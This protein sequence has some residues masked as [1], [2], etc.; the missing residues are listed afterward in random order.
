MARAALDQWTPVRRSGS[1][2]CAGNPEI[3]TRLS[4]RGT[5][6]PVGRVYHWFGCRLAR[7]LGVDEQEFGPV[8]PTVVQ[9]LDPHGA[10]IGYYVFDQRSRHAL[11]LAALR[12]SADGRES[13]LIGRTINHVVGE[14]WYRSLV[15][16]GEICDSSYAENPRRLV[17]LGP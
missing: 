6:L 17:L 15:E 12:P 7:V 4:G 11:G 8:V 9:H 1:R 13:N 2:H 10:D 14:F 3:G 5:D 16:A